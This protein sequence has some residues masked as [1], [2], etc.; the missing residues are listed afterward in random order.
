LDEIKLS[1]V[2]FSELSQNQKYD[3]INRILFNIEDYQ[4]NLNILNEEI[5]KRIIQVI[6]HQLDKNEKR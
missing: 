6:Y 2:K 4:N 3:F 5:K 1:N